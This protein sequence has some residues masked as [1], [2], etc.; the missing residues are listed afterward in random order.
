MRNLAG[1]IVSGVAVL[2][3]AAVPVWGAAGQSSASAQYMPP[4]GMASPA[5]NNNRMPAEVGTLNYVEGSV[6]LSGQSLNEKAVGS[7]VVHQGQTLITD[8]GRAE[9][10][11]T[12][13]VVVRLDDGTAVQMISSELTKTEIGLEN[14]RAAVEVGYIQ[15]ANDIS[16]AED[17]ATI[18]LMKPG[19]YEFDTA[20][21]SVRVFKKGEAVVQDDGHTINVKGD[22]E[23]ALAGNLKSQKFDEAKVQDDFYNFNSLRSSYLAEAN[24]DLAPNYYVAGGYYGPDWV[25]TGWYWDPWFDAYTWL[26]ADGLFF[27]PFGWGFYAPFYG[28][29]YGGGFY[30]RRYPLYGAYGGGHFY[31][32]F[33][34]GYRPNVAENFRGGAA[35]GPV[36]SF[37]SG[38]T[39]GPVNSFHGGMGMYNSGFRGSSGGG[40]HGFSGFHGGGFGGGGFHGGGGG[41]GR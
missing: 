7:A 30:G 16:V 17:G 35:R 2:A 8:H 24:V 14:G 13:G 21:S 41:H 9:I 12:P 31:H 34:P 29:F 26:P 3:L 36:N 28:G 5:A 32:H 15:P 18:R 4:Q 10:L 1:A 22:H 37:Q 40:F 20:H 23:L 27:D 19:L 11:L 38:V 25:G 6:T 33:G 39:R